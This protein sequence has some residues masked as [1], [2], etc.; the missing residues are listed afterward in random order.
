MLTID[1]HQI[2]QKEFL[3]IYQKNQQNL[4]SGDQTPVEDYL[5][6][7]IDFKLKVI[8]AENSQLDT[9]PSI[10]NELSKYRDELAKPYL[11]DQK[12]LEQLMRE[13]YQRSKQEVRAS[14]ILISIPRPAAYQDTLRAY[15]KIKSIRKRIRKKK[16]SFNAVAKATS[17][18][19][20]VKSNSGNLGFFTALQMVYPLENKAYQMKTHQIS[21]PFR[22]RHGYH[23]LKKTGERKAKGKIKVAHIMLLA[24]ESMSEAKRREKKEKINELYHRIKQG[25]SFEELARKHSEDKTSARQGGE[26]PWFGVGRMVPSFEKAAF[27]LEQKGTITQPVKTRIGWHIIKLLDRKTLKT[28]QEEKSQ[29]KR[30]ITQSPRYEIAQDSLIAELKNQYRVKE[31]KSHFN[32]LLQFV[33]E[34]AHQV[35]WDRLKSRA[36]NKTLFSIKDQNYST[37]DFIAYLQNLPDELEGKFRG[38]YLIDTAYHSFLKDKILDYEKQ[39][40]PEKYPDYQYLLQEYHDG[41]LLFEIMDRQVWSKASRD[42]TG[43]RQYYQNHKNQ[44]MWGERFRGRV[45]LCDDQKTLKKV[46]K[47]KKGGLFRKKYS[48]QQVLD[49]L[50]SDKEQQVRIQSGTFSKGENQVIDYHVWNKGSEKQVQDQ[51]PFL[52]KGEKIPPQPKS[53]DEARGA[54]LADYQNY[55]EEQW[56]E[57][58]KEKYTIQVNDQVLE[59]IKQNQ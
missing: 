49:E 21:Q 26:L 54:V 30:K 35:Q 55:L 58:L 41:I 25:A 29:I 23:L 59:Q 22:T 8:E 47:M 18:D 51:K 38:H 33:D 45:Y 27:S 57:K 7:F 46:R 1:D 44:Y 48:D 52:V 6:L 40:L 56:L 24:P 12:V 11:I 36:P 37:T 3:R 19:P 4:A 16:T 53:L 20:S 31:N 2:T 17:D 32:N 10:E 13:A 34:K 43:L 28:Y 39:R 14:H 42:T 9:L 15:N 5:D 50:N